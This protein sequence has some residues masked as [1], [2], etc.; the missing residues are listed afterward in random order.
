MKAIQ[1]NK[2]GGNEVIE[3]VTNASIPQ[4]IEGHI[5]VKVQK[6][7]INPIDFEIRSGYLQ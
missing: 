1:I 4:A 7:P 5:L 6:A 2:Y 3:I